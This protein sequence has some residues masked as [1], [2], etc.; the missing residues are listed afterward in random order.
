MFANYEIEFAAEPFDCLLNE[1]EILGVYRIVQEL[2]N[3]A[4]K[5]S[6][7]AKVR[8]A[9]TS[10]NRGVYFS[11]SDDGVGIDLASFESSFQHM[12]IT[13]IEKRVLSLG[14]EVRFNSSPGQGFHVNLS[15]PKNM[16][17]KGD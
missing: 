9:L 4:S 16:E 14:G 17:R 7:A 12:G 11:Y 5:H 13:G 3:N 6:A 8:M 10:D 1:E 2:L 15:I